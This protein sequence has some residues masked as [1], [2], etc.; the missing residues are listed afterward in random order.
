MRVGEGGYIEAEH[1]GSGDS[2]DGAYSCIGC[3]R[4]V[5]ESE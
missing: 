4:S 5:H 1:V 3:L 2:E